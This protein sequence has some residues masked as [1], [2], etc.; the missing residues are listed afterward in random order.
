M[1]NTNKLHIMSLKSFEAVQLLLAS[2]IRPAS[3]QRS[4][5]TRCRLLSHRVH[6]FF[7]LRSLWLWKRWP[8][9][10]NPDIWC[11][12][13]THSLIFKI[14]GRLWLFRAPEFIGDGLFVISFICA[15]WASHNVQ[16]RLC[17]RDKLRVFSM[18]IWSA[19]APGWK[20]QVP[21]WEQCRAKWQTA[22]GDRRPT[23]HSLQ[24]RINSSFN[25]FP[26]ILHFTLCAQKLKS[27]R[28]L[29]ENT[30]VLFSL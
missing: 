28:L 30:S 22:R 13:F 19:K 12:F 23:E 5:S 25:V 1:T 2:L 21:T 7:S 29:V 4:S 14:R 26:Y 24:G 20:S 6:S 3:C 15:L 8:I 18:G 10:P 9:E 17:H 27:S 16:V 11:H